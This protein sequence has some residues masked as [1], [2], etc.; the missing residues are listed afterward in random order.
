MTEEHGFEFGEDVM[1][2]TDRD[3]S[4][5]TETNAAFFNENVET[6]PV[7]STK[8]PNGVVAALQTKYDAGSQATSTTPEKQLLLL[9]SALYTYD[10]RS[11]S[12]LVKQADLDS[13]PPVYIKDVLPF[14][15]QLV[16]QDSC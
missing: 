3:T 14:A 4:L 8:S 7:V 11:L 1:P 13:D 6:T 10:V 12:A 15:R 16:R 2:A 5:S 9:G